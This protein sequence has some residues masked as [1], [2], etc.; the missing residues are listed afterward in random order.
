MTYHTPDYLALNTAPTQAY[1][2][3]HALHTFPDRNALNTLLLAFISSRQ[4]TRSV[5][6]YC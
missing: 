5:K 6:D 2:A 4:R 3:R 1:Q